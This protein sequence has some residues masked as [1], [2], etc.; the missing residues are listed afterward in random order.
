MIFNPFRVTK[1]PDD[2][3][4]GL[5]SPSYTDRPYSVLV[6]D[7][8]TATGTYTYLLGV[9]DEPG[10]ILRRFWVVPVVSSGVNTTD[11]YTFKPFLVEPDGTKVELGSRATNSYALTQLVPMTI[12]DAD[13]LGRSLQKGTVLGVDVVVINGGTL[14]DPQ[15]F[16]LQASTIYGG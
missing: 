7:A 11:Y 2:L 3:V 5:L 4:Q 12:H 13:T 15:A 9:V 1:D 8:P 14:V 10:K 16:V 6:Q